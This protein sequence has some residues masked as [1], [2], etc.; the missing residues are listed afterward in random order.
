MRQVAA[1]LLAT[2][3]ALVIAI[4]IIASLVA[5]SIGYMLDSLTV[6]LQPA[7]GHAGASSASALA[8]LLLLLLLGLTLRKRLRP[9]EKTAT[10]HRTDSANQLEHSRELI[11]KYPLESAA[12]AFIGGIA[13][14]SPEARELLKSTA[15][16]WLDQHGK[17]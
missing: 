3:V 10:A 15:R 8:G 7:L 5:F 12:L 11:Q 9:Q 16:S 4:T 6:V 14:E 13:A 1:R 17:D 2:I